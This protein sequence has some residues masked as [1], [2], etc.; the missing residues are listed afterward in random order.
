MYAMEQTESSG[1]PLAINKR[2]GA[3]GLFQILPGIHGG[4]EHYNTFTKGTNYTEND[5]FNPDVNIKIATWI[6]TGN[7]KSFR[8]CEVKT[9]NSFNMGVGN[10]RQ[11]RFYFQY[12]TNILGY[13]AV[14]N[15][16]NDYY[17]TNKS[18]NKLE[19]YI[20]RKELYNKG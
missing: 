18:R 2:T 5:L 13:T 4:L 14:S 1:N 8:G 6:I 3:R 17:V 12:C 15:Y 11:G 7:L 20:I 16:L 19:W 9:V 10:T